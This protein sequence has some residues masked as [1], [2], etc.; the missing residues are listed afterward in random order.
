[1]AGSGDPAENRDAM[2]MTMPMAKGTEA[3]W[4]PRP[5]ILVQ[6]GNFFFKYRDIMWPAAF[7]ALVLLFKP[8]VPMGGERMEWITNVIGVLFVVAGEALRV[9]VIGYEYIRRGGKDRRVYAD[10]L[11][12]GGLFAHARNPLYLGNF[13]AIVGFF[14]IHNNP[15]TYLIGIPFYALMYVSIVSAEETFLHGKFGAH[16]ED[17]C[18]RVNRFIPSFAGLSESVGGMKFDLQRVVRKEYGTLFLWYW[19]VLGLIVLGDYTRFGFDASRTEIRV[20]LVLC[21]VGAIAWGVCRYLKK[22]GTLGVG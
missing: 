5:R 10:D 19:I 11:V 9:T 7:L 6:A 13:L 15:W 18:Q 2:T 14:I 17:Y 4:R 3:S 22:K 12:T 16:Y 20:V 8:R 21:G 1:M